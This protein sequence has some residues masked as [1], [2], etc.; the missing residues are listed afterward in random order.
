MMHGYSGALFN[1][2]QGGNPATGF[3]S[4]FASSVTASSVQSL[5][6][7]KIA[8]LIGGTLSGG[9]GTAVVGG[10]FYQGATF[11]LISTSLNHLAEHVSKGVIAI[12][13]KIVEIAKSYVGSEDWAV[14]AE[15]DQ[16]GSNTNKCNKFVY[17]VHMEA[18]VDDGQPNL[19]NPTGTL[20]PFVDDVFGPVLAGQWADPSYE[21]P[22]WKV[23]SYPKPGDVI[24]IPMP[25][26]DGY[27][28]H[29]GI[30]TGARA[31]RN[32]IS[33]NAKVVVQNN[34]GFRT[35]DKAVYRRYVGP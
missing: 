18:G 30:V 33:A 9:V 10:D 16:F 23:V 12:R 31:Y 29:V 5:G 24:A 26:G 2:V 3:V 35:G 6:G 17:D 11:G 14:K 7:G 19:M 21:I 15:K 22:G 4:G 27:S 25:G 28:G 13:K 8:T 32:T 1:M 20:I 34:W